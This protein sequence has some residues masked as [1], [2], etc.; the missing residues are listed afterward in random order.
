MRDI[1]KNI[2]GADQLARLF[3]SYLKGLSTPSIMC[4]PCYTTMAEVHAF[5]HN[6]L[7]PKHQRM[8]KHS[9]KNFYKLTVLSNSLRHVHHHVLAAIAE[10]DQFFATYAGDL[11]RYAVDKRLKVIDENGSDDESDWEAD[12][13]NEQG[14]QKWKVTYKDDPESLKHYTLYEELSWHF[15]GKEVG[16]GEY[17]GT[18]G[19]ECF[20]PYSTLV[21]NQSA[22]SFRK[23]IE[24]FSG[25]PAQISSLQ[26]DGSMV[27]MTLGDHVEAE[28]NE[29]LRG[30][31]QVRWFN[32]ALGFC[33][34]IRE[35]YK[36]M[37]PG[38]LLKYKALHRHLQMVRDLDFPG[39]VFDMLMAH[40]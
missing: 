26:P 33:V 35:R 38:D 39:E 3:N 29:D 32:I 22:F 30:N 1:L 18:S 36:A 10:L 34:V 20:E 4:D 25:Q 2:E 28:L 11:Q 14:G 7:K 5:S 24:H 21:A 13:L 16:R 27:P 6:K 37:N 8:L 12:G 23:F 15:G 9:V 19:P 40:Q 17:I 31:D